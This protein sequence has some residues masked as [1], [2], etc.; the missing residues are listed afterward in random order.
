MP[1]RG[2]AGAA[3]REAGG[4]VLDKGVDAAVEAKDAKVVVMFVCIAL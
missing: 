1:R 2:G 3:A 4:D